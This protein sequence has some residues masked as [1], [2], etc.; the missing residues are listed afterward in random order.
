MVPPTENIKKEILVVCVMCL[1][2]LVTV[3]VIGSN[4]VYLNL[5]LKQP[6]TSL[7]VFCKSKILLVRSMVHWPEVSQCIFCLLQFILFD[8]CGRFLI[9]Q[10]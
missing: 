9:L 2:Y 4:K 6:N 1:L 7:F 8:I 3:Y 5:N 10:I